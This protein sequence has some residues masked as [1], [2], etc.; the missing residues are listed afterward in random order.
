MAARAYPRRVFAPK[1]GCP[2][3]ADKT[4]QAAGKFRHGV[5]VCEAK[6]WELPLGQGK[7]DGAPSTQM[8]RYLTRVDVMSE[9]RILWGVLIPRGRLSL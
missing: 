2:S 8:L 6:K 1:R 7:G 3:A 4:K 9:G 5:V